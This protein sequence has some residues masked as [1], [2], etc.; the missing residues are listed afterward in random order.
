MTQNIYEIMI[1]F[2][3]SG[4]A[5]KTKIDDK[6]THGL[7]NVAILKLKI[8]TEYH[9]PSYDEG[10]ISGVID[11]YMEMIVQFGYLA[12]FSIAFSLIP[13]IAIMN[14]LVETVIDR[15]K[16]LEYTRRPIQQSAKSHG[17]FTLLIQVIAF[18]AI[19]SN[20]GI[21]CFTG[22][23]FGSGDKQFIGF[24]W[25]NVLFYIFRFVLQEM[26]PDEKETTYN[27]RKRHTIVIKR[28][29]ARFKQ[30]SHDDDEDDIAHSPRSEE[31]NKKS[32][33]QVVDSG[34]NDENV[35]D[36]E[37]EY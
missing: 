5:G 12:L 34:D 30:Y 29:L 32:R 37:D 14:N 25:T 16:L 9:K 17:I 4:K 23:A 15:K 22:D 1:P 3:K 18:W 36:S 24:L 7:S 20:L 2:L 28:T 27:I 13:L 8:H 10:E 26:I 6:T 11:E 21:V 31:E 35:H 33:Y 19:F